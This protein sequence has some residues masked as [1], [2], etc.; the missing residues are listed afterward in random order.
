MQQQSEQSE[1]LKS[2][3]G[4]VQNGSGRCALVCGAV[5]PRA[6]AKILAKSASEFRSEFASNFRLSLVRIY[7]VYALILN[8]SSSE[9]R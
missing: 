9:F 6:V 1:Q 5:R 2:E 4:T 3:M 7:P 8:I